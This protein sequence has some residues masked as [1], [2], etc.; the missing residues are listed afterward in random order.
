MKL[1]A[2]WNSVW[3]NHYLFLAIFWIPG[4]V[5]FE[6]LRMCAVLGNTFLSLFKAIKKRALKKNV[7]L[8]IVIIIIIQFY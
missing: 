8:I 3:S 7:V 5:E 6:E 1:R 4:K 2:M